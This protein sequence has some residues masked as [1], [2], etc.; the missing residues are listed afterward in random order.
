LNWAVR[1]QTKNQRFGE[2]TGTR[3]QNNRQRDA[4]AGGYRLVGDARMAGR[5]RGDSV[6]NL[7]R[8]LAVVYKIDSM[9]VLLAGRDLV[10]GDGRRH[11]VKGKTYSRTEAELVM[12]SFLVLGENDDPLGVVLRCVGSFEFDRDLGGFSGENF[13]GRIDALHAIALGTRGLDLPVVIRGVFENEDDAVK[14]LGFDEFE[15][16]LDA[17]GENRLERL[18]RWF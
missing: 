5:I 3:A 9:F 10:E 8:N 1:V 7:D 4:A 2:R 13:L 16:V 15:V 17:R 18:G 14:G 12:G 11:D 6:E